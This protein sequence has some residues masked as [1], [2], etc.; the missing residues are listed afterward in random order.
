CGNPGRPRRPLPLIS[1]LPLFLF[2]R[3]T[4]Q[5]F[6]YLSLTASTMIRVRKKLL[7]RHDPSPYRTTVHK[8][9]NRIWRGGHG[10]Y[11]RRD[12]YLGI[13][14]IGPGIFPEGT[15]IVRTHLSEY[16]GHLYL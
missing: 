10:T 2:D 16:F 5:N 1:K 6:T 8:Q 11:S 4:D 15:G 14:Q 7:I 12:H 13:G 9:G 3:S